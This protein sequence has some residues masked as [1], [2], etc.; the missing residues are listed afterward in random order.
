MCF[1][2][3]KRKPEINLPST[4]REQVKTKKNS[5]HDREE[6]EAKPRAEKVLALPVV[7]EKK[8]SV[9]AEKKE[10]V[11]K[12]EEIIHIIDQIDGNLAKRTDN[13]NK[14]ETLLSQIDKIKQIDVKEGDKSAIPM[15]VDQGNPKPEEKKRK[16]TDYF[17]KV[18][19]HV[20]SLL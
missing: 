11:V 8:E 20:N 6:D 17:C 12:P 7:V 10:T 2:T 4:S 15:E 16:I 3:Q 1:G 14:E 9:V 5:S 19:D 18:T 13:G